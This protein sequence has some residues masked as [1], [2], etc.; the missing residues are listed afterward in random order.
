MAKK[1]GRGQP[2]KFATPE[3]LQEKIDAYF[4]ECEEKEE[5][6]TITGLALALDTTRETLL[7]YQNNYE[8]EYSDVVRK[9]KQRVQNNAEKWL[10]SGKHPTGAIFWLKA[11]A[12]WVDKQVHEVSGSLEFAI[13]KPDDLD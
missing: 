6:C 12:G 4:V 11:N 5:P 8:Q 3:I 7:D 10:F 2:K 9:A 1:R 13:K